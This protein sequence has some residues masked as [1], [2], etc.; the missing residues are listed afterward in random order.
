MKSTRLATWCV[1]LGLASFL[2]LNSQAQITVDGTREAAYGTPLS[3]QLV[4]SGW[5][6][7]NVLASLSAKQEGGSLKV[8]L[9]GR[10]DGN[11]FILFIDSKSGGANVI[12]TNTITGGGEE[13]AINNFGASA[14]AGMTFETDFSPDYAIR[15]HGGGWTA[16]YPLAPGSLRQNLGQSTVATVSGG[17]VAALRTVYNNVTGNYADHTTG[18]EIDLSLAGLGVPTGTGQNV[19][20]MAI[21][22]NQ[23]SDYASNQTLGSLPAGSGDLGNGF[24]T[25]N[26]NTVTGTQTISMTVDNTDAD[27]DGIPDASD[28]D[29]DND[30][31]TDVVETNTGT[32][33]DANDTGSNPLV[34]D[35]DGDG[36]NDG[37]EVTAGRDPNKYNYAQITIAGGFQGWSPAPTP[38]NAPANVMTAVPAGSLNYELLWRFA[39]AT[40]TEGKFTAGSWSVSWGATTNAGIAGLGADPNIPFN[41]TASGVWKFAFNTD[42]RAYSFARLAAPGT[43]DDWAAQYGLAAGSGAEDADSDSLSNSQEFAA[44]SDPANPDTDGDNLPDAFEVN[45]LNS[46]NIV[47]SPITADTDGDGLRDAW[48]LEYGLDPTDNG[49]ATSYVNNTGLSVSTNPNGASADPDADTLTNLQEQIANSNPLAAGTGF[50]S[51]YPKITVPGSFNG[52][53]ASGNPANTMQLVG[54]FSW[55]LIVYFASVPVSPAYKFAAGSWSTN[56]GDANPSDGVAN[57]NGGDISGASVFTAPGYYAITFNDSTLAYSATALATGDL[58]NDGLPDEWEAYYGSF[59][60]PKITDLVPGTAY[61]AGSSTTAA[62]A[63]AAGTHPTR[64]TTAPTLQLAAGV[65]RVS[66]VEKN[67]TVT[68]LPTDVT[69]SD[70][71]TTN[72]TPTLNIRVNGTDQQSV[73]TD[74]DG[75]AVITYTAT[76]AAGNSASLTRTI[77]IGNAEPGYRNVRFP[78]AMTVNTLSSDFA[79]G[80]IFV[81]GATAGA[82][83]ATGINVWIGVNTN[84]TDPATWDNAVWSPAN[85]VGEEGNNDNYQGQISGTGRTPGTAYYYATRFQMGT[86]NTNYHFGGIGTDGVGG[87]WGGTREVVVGGVTNTVTNGNGLL[88][89]QSARTLTFAVNMNVQTNKSLFTPASQGVE[90]RGSF[91]S[92]TWA[93]GQATLTD[94]DSDGIYTG[95]FTVAG[96]LGTA[97]QYKFYR[98]G[99]SGAG[100]EGLANDRSYTLGANG[101]NATIDTAFFNNDDG[102]GPVITRTGDATINLAV[103]DSYTDAGATATDVIDGTVTVTPSGTVNTAVAGTYTITYNA[104]DAAGNAATPVTRTV[105]VA[106]ADLLADYLGGFGLTGANAAGNADPDGD[107][108]DNNAELAF[109]TDPT[110]G[111]SR[112]AT[113]ATG[114]GTIKLVY[115]QRNT[116]VTYTVKSF[117]DL[118]TPFDSGGTAVTPTATDPQPVGIRAGY[119]QYEASLSTGSTRGF[120][121][122]KAVR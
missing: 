60:E 45:G 120:L 115:L 97:I 116:G 108:M 6:A 94:P 37:A 53:N 12:T 1:A 4:T 86:N 101:V 51:A 71:I 80:E 59:L 22:I 34:A 122:V 121:R 10:P 119:T 36:M 74:A 48:E 13:Y 104:S 105:V 18:V 25:T 23:G 91:T 93:G 9:A 96:D 114:T 49:S 20:F 75:F 2:S 27:G 24:K 83:A 16:L 64:D 70:A 41:V 77:A 110:N 61:V 50:A 98:T 57:P 33:V 55:K 118:S 102:I 78:A 85:Y 32:F 113:L 87:T 111:A 90:V 17:P 100:F 15:I 66:W 79:Y 84:N 58:D 81:E 68:P 106:A 89:V 107:G 35:T 99:A 30:G 52:F 39:T 76:D 38:T 11:A 95:S 44:N 29:D 54:N 3:V 8:F 88:T 65:D 72:I 117:T 14:S 69:V 40:N 5:G 67:G 42:T 56:W 46:F 109:G 47:T 28:P 103:G 19:K 63:Y 21:L 73:L 92:P 31:L 82:G 7:N 43:Y 62:E 26:F 112:A